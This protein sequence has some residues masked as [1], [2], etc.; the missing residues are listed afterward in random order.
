MRENNFIV[1]HKEIAIKAV[2]ERQRHHDVMAH[3]YR[4]GL[5]LLSAAPLL[6]APERRVSY[7][8]VSNAEQTF[9]SPDPP[10]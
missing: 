10:M 7:V 8:R 2:G 3:V 1:K 6:S 4:F 9:V 5:R